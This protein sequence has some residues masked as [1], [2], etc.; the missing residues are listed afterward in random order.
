MLGLGAG[1]LSGAKARAFSGVERH[2][3][4]RA[5]PISFPHLEFF[6][7]PLKSA[8]P[9]SFMRVEPHHFVSSFGSWKSGAL[10]AIP[11]EQFAV[12]W[13]RLGKLL[14]GCAGVPRR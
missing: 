10:G 13:R 9:K 3:Q 12:L 1:A 4:S 8:L 11:I 14:H 2:N 5:L 7:Q 6:P